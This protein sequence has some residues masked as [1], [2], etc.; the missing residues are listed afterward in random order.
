MNEQS[1]NFLNEQSPNCS[2]DCFQCQQVGSIEGR[3][4]IAM[5]TSDKLRWAFSG[6]NSINTPD[7]NQINIILSPLTG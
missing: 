5:A 3:D 1:L 6:A 4:S 2:R 7:C